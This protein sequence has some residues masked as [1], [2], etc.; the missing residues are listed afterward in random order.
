[1]AP[2][3]ALGLSGSCSAPNSTQE[4]KTGNNPEKRALGPSGAAGPLASLRP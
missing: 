3:A 1:M 4:R 2:D